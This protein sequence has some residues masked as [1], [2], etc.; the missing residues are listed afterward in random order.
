M[1]ARLSIT[2]TS[3]FFSASRANRAATARIRGSQAPPRKCLPQP[4]GKRLLVLF[5]PK[6]CL[7]ETF[8]QG[9]TPRDAIALERPKKSSG[10]LFAAVRCCLGR[11]SA[12]QFGD[13]SVVLAVKRARRRSWHP[14]ERNFLD[15][16]GKFLTI[17]GEDER[18]FK[19]H[20]ETHGV[21]L[22][23]QSP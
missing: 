16:Y 1:F 11:L 19:Y 15:F 5:I 18:L 2:I 8:D 3:V 14:A 10:P 17:N 21:F 23:H 4:L 12:A 9:L 22:L 6:Y 7:R 20:M 13:R